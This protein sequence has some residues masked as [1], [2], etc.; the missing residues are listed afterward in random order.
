[1]SLWTAIG[2]LALAI[3]LY[4]LVA[5]GGFWRCRER[6]DGE[7]AAPARWPAARSIA[8]PAAKNRI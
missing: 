1:M 2:L 5:R 8:I 6:D 7:F 3:W 4:L